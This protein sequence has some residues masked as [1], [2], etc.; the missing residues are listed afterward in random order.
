[1]LKQRGIRSSGLSTI[2]PFSTWSGAESEGFSPAP[3][4]FVLHLFEGCKSLLI[5]LNLR[6]NESLG[7]YDH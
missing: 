3:D 1:M 2:Q 7:R 6:P 5:S 4:K